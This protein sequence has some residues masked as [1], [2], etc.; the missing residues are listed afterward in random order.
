MQPE[1][2]LQ[3]RDRL[4]GTA[5]LTDSGCCNKEESGGRRVGVGWASGEGGDRGGR[6]VGHRCL[7][8]SNAYG[9][10]SYI[11]NL[12]PPITMPHPC[13]H[14]QQRVFLC[15]PYPMCRTMM[16]PVDVS[17][18]HFLYCRASVNSRWNMTAF[19]EVI[20]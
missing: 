1:C 18:C 14:T 17:S 12:L 8:E 11:Y 7:Q 19:T 2:R 20:T 9:A 3:S 15:L 16:V 4:S 5:A 6:A 13:A 10:Q